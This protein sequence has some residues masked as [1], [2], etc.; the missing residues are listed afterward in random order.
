MVI[1]EMI[2]VW[3]TATI[4]GWNVHMANRVNDRKWIHYI[5]LLYLDVLNSMPSGIKSF[6]IVEIATVEL[7]YFLTASLP[8]TR[9]RT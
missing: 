3:L 6:E 9:C 7:E 1:L 5:I 4:S 8:M 2:D